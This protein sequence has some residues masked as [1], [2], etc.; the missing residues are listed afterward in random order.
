MTDWVSDE[1]L[2]LN[3][4]DKRVDKSAKNLIRELAT[5]PGVS[6]TQAFETHSEVKFC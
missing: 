3:L 4:G 6:I 1:F 5:Q 2:L